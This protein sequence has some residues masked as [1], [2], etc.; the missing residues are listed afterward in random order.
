MALVAKVSKRVL[1]ETLKESCIKSVHT[2][3]ALYNH[4][5]TL[6]MLRWAGAES[7]GSV[8]G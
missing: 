5:T 3:M 1:V 6:D 7:I 2:S 4:R 8:G